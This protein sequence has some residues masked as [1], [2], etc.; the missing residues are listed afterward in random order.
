M[1]RKKMRVS[2][3]M[4]LNLLAFLLAHN[5]ALYLSWEFLWEATS[6]N[7][8]I[9]MRVNVKISLK[10]LLCKSMPFLCIFLK[11]NDTFDC[12]SFCM[13]VYLPVFLFF[14]LSLF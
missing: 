9:S 7:G 1:D 4:Q 10:G 6:L 11:E 14:S 13:T 5:A 3:S 8:S 2:L 12:M